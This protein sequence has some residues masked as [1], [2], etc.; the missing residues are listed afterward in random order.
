MLSLAV[1]A[2][3]YSKWQTAEDQGRTY[4][5][6]AFTSLRDRLRDPKVVYTENTISAML[7]LMS[8]EVRF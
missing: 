1:A 4:L 7:S 6:K 3:H 2:S 5:T 8:Y